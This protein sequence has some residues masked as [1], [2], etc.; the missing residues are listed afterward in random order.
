MTSMMASTSLW[1][2][3]LKARTASTDTF[4]SRLSGAWASKPQNICVT[5]NFDDGV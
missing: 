1:V 3:S 2:T 5:T 4:R